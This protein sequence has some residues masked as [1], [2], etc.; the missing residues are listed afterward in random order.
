MTLRLAAGL[1]AAMACAAFAGPPPTDAARIAYL[2][3]RVGNLE[4]QRIAS[5]GGDRPR[6][7]LAKAIGD[8]DR[9]LAAAARDAPAS[10]REHYAL[11]ELLWRQHRAWLQRA[12]T[13]EGLAALRERD[14]ELAWLADRGRTLAGVP[15]STEDEA[16]QVARLAE[17]VSRL[18]VLRR[19]LPAAQ[20]A[21]DPA[22]QELRERI[23]A[24]Q[25]RVAGREGLEGEVAVAR[26]QLDFLVR[27]VA[28]RPFGAREADVA[29]RSADH[30]AESLE[31]ALARLSASPG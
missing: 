18:A 30:A 3:E 20:Q 6:R 4:A 27:A 19:S 9:T 24:L 10:M 5:V 13:R 2:V 28:T 1:A 26:G 14:D 31:R 17:R 12:A 22:L 23:A 29:A 15:P 16:W 11:F 7:A 8:V 21:L 25:A